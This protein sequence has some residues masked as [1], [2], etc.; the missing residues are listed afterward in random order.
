MKKI[1]FCLFMLL[2]SITS[3]SQDVI[4][5]NKTFKVQ[6]IQVKEIQEIINK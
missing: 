2:F 4:K 6:T 5:G 3:Y 1:I